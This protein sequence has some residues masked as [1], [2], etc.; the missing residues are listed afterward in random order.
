[1]DLTRIQKLIDELDRKAPGTPGR[2]T[3]YREPGRG[4]Y[5]HSIK[6]GTYDPDT[7]K[8]GLQRMPLWAYKELGDDKE[9]LDK[10]VTRLNHRRDQEAKA[11]QLYKIKSAYIQQA[12]LDQFRIVS[13]LGNTPEYVDTT[14]LYLRKYVL[15][16]LSR[17]DANPQNW[18]SQSIQAEWANYL[19]REAGSRQKGLSASALKAVVQV[20]NRFM[21]FMHQRYPNE[22]SLILL[23]PLNKNFYRNARA[24]A[25]V[26][27]HRRYVSFP[28]FMKVLT[29]LDK[30]VVPYVQFCYYFG[31][32]RNESMGLRGHP[33]KVWKKGLRIDAQS[34]GSVAN[35]L[36]PTKGR[37]ERT[38]P[39]WYMDKSAAM[40][41]IDNMRPMSEDTITE[42]F[43]KACDSIGFPYK[44]H[45]LRHTFATNVVFHITGLADIRQ[46]LGHSDLAVTNRYI[47]ASAE[48]QQQYEVEE[49]APPF[50]GNI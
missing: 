44:V 31:L 36:V 22:L 50:L 23:E 9:V 32:R 41:W 30:S 46:A 29:A 27:G 3:V 1:M 19:T 34:D 8:K 39:Y 28:D 43:R 37:N 26:N 24:E 7:G 14:M 5:L 6:R 40:A 45:D 35:H 17:L 33:E 48:L 16:P 11:R 18:N 10:L 2:W 13:E 4:H 49:I 42:K 21:K 15:D 25:R 47:T 38:V 12:D 20:A